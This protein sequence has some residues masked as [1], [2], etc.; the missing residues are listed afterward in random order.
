MTRRLERLAIESGATAAELTVWIERQWL[1]PDSQ[2]GEIAFNDADRA[3]LAMIVEFRRDLSIDDE[4]MPVVLDLVD[5]LHAAR[6]QLRSLLEA[7]A[8]LPPA[9]QDLFLRQ[10]GGLQ[11]S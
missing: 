7:V 1:R 4:A 9:Q 8:G 2:G 11:D 10:L 3:R 5:R 6:A